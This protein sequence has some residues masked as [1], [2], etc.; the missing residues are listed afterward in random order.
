VNNVIGSLSVLNQLSM[1]SNE[2]IGEFSLSRLDA[3]WIDCQ[4]HKVM[5]SVYSNIIDPLSV[6]NAF[7]I[8]CNSKQAAIMT[9]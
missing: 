7:Y 2:A 5:V 9:L 4:Q 3:S 1:A 8:N 6:L